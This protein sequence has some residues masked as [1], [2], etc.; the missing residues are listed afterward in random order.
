M[1]SAFE[2]TLNGRSIRV[3]DVSPNTTLLEY[4]RSSGLT[5]TKEGCAEGDCGACSVAI[6]ERDANG[7]AAYRAVNSCLM[8]ICLL[9]GRDVV[10]VEGICK[11]EIRNP[12]SEIEKLHPVQRAMAEGYGAQCGYCTPGFICSLFEG[13]YRN[14]LHTHDDL[15]DQLSGNL[16]RC[17]GYRPIRDAAMEAFQCGVRSAECGIKDQFAERLQYS[18][19]RLGAAAYESAGEKFLRPVSLAELFQSLNANPEARLIAGATE[20]GLEITKRYKKFSTL[21]SI[22]AVAELREIK[23]TATEWHIGG[24]VTL[25]VI[26][27]KL[28]A[29][30]S[31]LNDMLRVFGSRQIRNRATMGGN[32][33][34]ASPIGDSA[35]CLLALEASVVLASKK[36]ERAL[37]VGEF[38]L[39]YRKTA[40]QAG[41]VLKT[42]I[43]P[44]GVSAAGL[45]RKTAW[46]K[47]S[48][49]REMD[50][51]T[52]AGAFVVDLDSKNVVRHVRLGY[53]GVAAMPAR[54][55]QTEAAL[56][57]KAW[58]A[59]TIQS[60]L[61][62][63]RTEFTP[64][65]DVRGTAEYRSGL[66]TSLLEKFECST[67]VSRV[68]SGVT[69][70]P[71]S[72]KLNL[73]ERN[74]RRDAENHPPEAGAT[75]TAH[76]S[77]HKH[78]TGESIYTDDFGARRQMLE[79]WPVC[80]PHAR[81]KI[82][83]RDASAARTMPGVAAVLLAEDVP[84]V[85]DV[86][87][88]RHDEV[89]LADKEVFY[90]G[91]I[92]ALVV[93]ETQEACRNAAAKI[94]VEYEPLP[95]ILKIEDAIAQ[96][97]VHY[98]PNFIRRGDVAKIFGVVSRTFDA[99]GEA[100][101]GFRRDAEN[102]PRDAG[103]TATTTGAT[104]ILEG[105][106]S[107]GGQEHFYLEM[108]AAYAEPGEEGSMFV[109]S[110]TQHPS[111]VQ[112]IVAHVL[113]V[114]TN[115]VVVQS[116]RM[117][118]GFGG[119]ETQA[120]MFAALAALAAAKTRQ[121]V[122]VRVNRDLDMMITGKRHPFLA[123]F[124]V[125]H[126]AE[127]R[128]LAA[129]V[130]LFSNAGWSLDLSMPVTDRAMF[131]LD[132]AY[133]IPNVEFS[134]Q[135][136]K[137]NVA[138]NTA[139]RGF[140]GPQGM[141]VIE[142]ILDRVA[143]RLGK[144]PEEVRE[145]NLYHG[146]GETNTTHYGQEIADN[147]I[148]RVWQ[149]LK[150][151]SEFGK[152][153][154]EIAEWNSQHPQR[155][156]GLAMT[157]VKFGISFTLTHLNQAGALVLIYQDGTVQVNHGATEMGQGVHTNM[158]M[159]TAKELGISLKNVR[160]MPT[161]TDKVP[162]TSATAASC[163]TDLN[164]MAVK[165]ACDILRERLAPVAAKMLAAKLGREIPPENIF[166]ANDFVFEAG[167]LV[168][169]SIQM[170][171][172]NPALMDEISRGETAIPFAKVVQA[173]YVQRIG[174][175]STGYYRTPEIHY[176][177]AKGQGKP[178]HYFAVGAAVT[179]VEVD[180][181]TGM[182]R[183]LRADLLQDC[184]N[185]INPGINIGQIEGAYVQGAGW[186]TCEELVWNDQGVLLTH[187]P[188]TYKIPAVGDRPLEFN[189][190]LLK[191]AEQANT[192]FG[193]KAVGEPPFMLAISVREAIR[194]AVA[195]FGS[196]QGEVAL[197]SPATGEAIW[198]A[199]QRVKAPSTNIQ[200][201]EK[202]QTPSSKQTGAMAI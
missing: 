143:R 10:S 80:A 94:V 40:L 201:P 174:L 133:Y 73:V 74:F 60:V 180:G 53:G 164:G 99:A 197:A 141:L 184:G 124:K 152:R 37:P 102:H 142:E 112:H 191:D 158:A 47:V 118:G 114:P 76:E 28:G 92:I 3:S 58:S 183:I 63:L 55:K 41:E 120:A 123:R 62:V 14:D 156:R 139:F 72:D 106:F 66:I 7:K 97:S 186:L 107:F 128:L 86:G 18:E 65:S 105:E 154:A 170:S 38:F 75:K 64:I 137:T 45:T 19:A 165:N 202:L 189:V 52:V 98:E 162:N 96:N 87:A 21:I 22:E 194:D 24:A 190:K 36:G 83:K 67:R 23:S 51:S 179:E 147:R 111:E 153:R 113:Q 31:M 108:Q 149:E 131:H 192:I 68:G 195:A 176:D 125:G 35:P 169:E 49:R 151:S 5:G 127:G 50:I 140:G 198:R 70:K 8:P 126:D 90:H 29:E 136:M 193:S 30:F 187:S 20:L 42:I 146:T 1:A 200:A 116:P 4:L 104:Q 82:L 101:P 25:T 33:V 110:S 77:A 161:S 121:A 117:G 88:V 85:N 56:L 81:A 172:Q 100:T 59:E 148:Q 78:V 71:S 15:D 144:T 13:Y 16:C 27:D 175:S 132:N 163:G 46:L 182:M 48:K 199:I 159:V 57:G 171:T 109:M 196:G 129:K 91:Q 178:F 6:V 134:G 115:H 181:F 43:I 89:L 95:P 145:R 17:T 79:V 9:A 166:F 54:A 32:I 155:K 44:R 119:K 12:K 167:S 84:G 93:G 138:S 135:A 39:A 103:A 157:P 2:F 26:K 168:A 185:S 122:R 160:V 69:P 11:S 177:R 34:T 61:P 188:D 150:Q 173:A 130:E